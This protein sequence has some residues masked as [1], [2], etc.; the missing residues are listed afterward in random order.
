MQPLAIHSPATQ[1]C[2]QPRYAEHSKAATLFGLV[3]L[4]TFEAAAAAQTVRVNVEILAATPGTVLH[5][6]FPFLLVLAGG[7]DRPFIDLHSILDDVVGA[8]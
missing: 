5:V 6:G 7:E 8:V 4:R 2:S 1:P 3:F